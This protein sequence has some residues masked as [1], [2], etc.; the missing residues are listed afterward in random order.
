MLHEEKLGVGE[1]AMGGVAGSGVR[2]KR[3]G[4]REREDQEREITRN[5][6]E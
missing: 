1:V 2:V 5:A 3:E 4:A 6:Q